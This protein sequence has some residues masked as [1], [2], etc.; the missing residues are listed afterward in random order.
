MDL[1]YFRSKIVFFLFVCIFFHA[2]LKNGNVKD[3]ENLRAA[4]WYEIGKTICSGKKRNFF[5]FDSTTFLFWCYELNEFLGRSRPDSVL[6]K[7]FQIID[8]LVE[9]DCL[10]LLTN[11]SD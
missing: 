9:S 10:S 6:I 1:I 5:S 8:F 7:I 2:K 4:L 11:Q 3:Y